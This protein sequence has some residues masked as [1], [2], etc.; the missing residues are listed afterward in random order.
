MKISSAFLPKKRS[1]SPLIGAFALH[2]YGYVRATGDIDF[3]VEGRR[4][5]KGRYGSLNHSGM[6]PY[7]AQKDFQIMFIRSRSLGRMD[8]VY[9][10]G[11]TAERI[12]SGAKPLMIFEGLS[13]P[14]VRPEHLIALKIFAMKNDPERSFREMADIQQLLSLTSKA[15]ISTRLRAIL[16][17]TVNWRSSMSLPGESK[18]SCSKKL[19]DLESGLALTPEDFRAMRSSRGGHDPGPCRLYNVAGGDRR[20]Q[21]KK[22]RCENIPGTV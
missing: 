4:A 5:G 8:F 20:F 7:I 21:N 9:V 18:K 17:S 16:K 1:I 2:A 13:V 6:K 22:S 11:E 3:A 14:V 15:W 19:L 12:F 10:E